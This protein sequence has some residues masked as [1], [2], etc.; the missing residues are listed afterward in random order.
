MHLCHMIFFP[1]I[2]QVSNELWPI[3]MEKIKNIYVLPTLI[4]CHFVTTSFDLW[5]SKA[6]HDIF[7]LVIKFLGDNWQPKHIT[8]GLF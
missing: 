6:S 4:K 7:A 8:L 3:L 5:M 2:K 1:S